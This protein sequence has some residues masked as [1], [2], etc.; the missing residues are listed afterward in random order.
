MA[1]H[2]RMWVIVFAG[3]AIAALALLSAGLPGLELQPGRPLV[4]EQIA[5]RAFQGFLPADASPL[6]E[7]LRAV[8]SALALVCVALLPFAIIHLILSPQAR[9]R[10][11]RDLLILAAFLIVYSMALLRVGQLANA[12][13]APAAA[14][15]A[16]DQVVAEFTPPSEWLTFWVSLG[17]A[18]AATLGG[19]LLWRRLRPAPAPLQQLAR[20][21]Q[22]AIEQLRAGGD[23]K[24]TVIRCYFEMSRALNDRQG[25]RR[26]SGMTPR[27]FERRLAGMGLPADHVRRLTRLFE[28]ARYS[29][30]TPGERDEREAVACLSAIVEACKQPP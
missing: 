4:F 25:I 3:L 26:P 19:W 22:T 30:D 13:E 29:P 7:F 28:A 15:P 27:E 12:S 8:W 11:I 23:L 1:K 20:E 5:P 17:L 6:E 24:N 16:T 14:V 9:K 10:V 18:G 21:A 2:K